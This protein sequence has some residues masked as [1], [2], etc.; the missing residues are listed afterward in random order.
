MLKKKT[1]NSLWIGLRWWWDVK[2]ALLMCTCVASSEA[3]WLRTGAKS[4]TVDGIFL[5]LCL[6][7]WLILLFLHLELLLSAWLFGHIFF[8]WWHLVSPTTP[9]W[10]GVQT[11]C[12][13]FSIMHTWRD[14]VYVNVN[15]HYKF[16]TKVY[17]WIGL[18]TKLNSNAAKIS[19]FSLSIPISLFIKIFCN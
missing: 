19:G 13:A 7:N 9:P 16:H 6:G 4:L 15:S 11:Y 2:V 14:G 5:S 8:L 17:W 12:I 18:E 3:V 10:I 1:E